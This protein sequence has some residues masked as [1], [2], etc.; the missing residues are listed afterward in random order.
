MR[1]RF[2]PITYKQS[3]YLKWS[4]LQQHGGL[5]EE[6]IKEF[7]RLAIVCE[8]EESEEL[9]VGRFLAGLDKK[10]LEKVE[11]YPNLTIDEACKL[12]IKLDNQRKKKKVTSSSYDPKFQKTKPFLNIRLLL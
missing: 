11:V 2:I 3:L 10:I 8:I 7:T 12:A 5:L 4:N 9:K 1:A 6:Y